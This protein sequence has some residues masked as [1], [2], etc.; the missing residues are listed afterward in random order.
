MGLICDLKIYV[1]NIPYVIMLN[2]L[3]NSVIDASYS[4]C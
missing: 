1:H 3:Q 2:M 4:R